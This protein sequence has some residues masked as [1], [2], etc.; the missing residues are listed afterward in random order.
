MSIS[1]LISSTSEGDVGF[2]ILTAEKMGF[3]GVERARSCARN[4]WP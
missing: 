2:C 1:D 3:E 4:T